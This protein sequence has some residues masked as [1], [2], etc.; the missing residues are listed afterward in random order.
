MA[1]LKHLAAAASLAVLLPACA[2][3]PYDSSARVLQPPKTYRFLPDKAVLAAEEAAVSNTG[4]WHEQVEAAIAR[5]LATKGYTEIK[6]GDTD[7]ILA[8]HVIIHQDNKTTFL[9]NYA[10]YEL[11]AKEQA[12]QADIRKYLTAPGAKN[13]SILIIDVIDP[14]KR[15]VV[16]REWT[17]APARE[18]LTAREQQRRIEGA[19]KII[20][21]QFPPK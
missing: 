16:W 4:Y 12:E 10:G 9:D 7:L 20:F 18:R 19:V 21:S 15:E 11:S 8:F 1:S 17:Q 3:A 2:T 14:K 6:S 13:R 5:K